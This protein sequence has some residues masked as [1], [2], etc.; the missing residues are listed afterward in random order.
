MTR[1]TLL[2]ARRGGE[3][4]RLF[5]SEWEEAENNGWIH[6]EILSEMSE[7]EKILVNSLKMAYLAGKGRHVV[8][9][10]IPKDTVKAMKYLA[11]PDI[12]EI[13]EL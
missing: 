3:V 13:M 12:R 7:A 6:K 9:V 2:N 5:I 11:R 1:L 8:S 10:I 4:G